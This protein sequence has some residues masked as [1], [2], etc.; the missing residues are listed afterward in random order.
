MH[1]EPGGIMDMH[2]PIKVLIAEDEDTFSL[3]L[4]RILA[5]DKGFDSHVYEFGDKVIEALQAQR[6]DVIILDYKLPERSG[7]SILQW[8]ADHKID[9][10]V[11]ILTGAGSENVAVEAMKL[12]AYDYIPKEHF[13]KDHLVH[14]VNAA[15]ERYVLRKER[16]VHERAA[17]DQSKV[18]GILEQLSQRLRSI[19]SSLRPG[20]K[21]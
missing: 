9:T 12:G 4:G 13:D 20:K 16:A 8:M 17:G 7:L 10:P 21:K 3:V 6:F 2:T 11:I 14:I 5:L 18:G 19:F 1:H 15:H